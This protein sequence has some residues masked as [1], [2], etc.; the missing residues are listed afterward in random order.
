M[1]T[2]LLSNEIVLMETN[3][4]KHIR[5]PWK[6]QNFDTEDRFQD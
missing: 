4:D 1:F 2:F 3:T 6:Y 5:L